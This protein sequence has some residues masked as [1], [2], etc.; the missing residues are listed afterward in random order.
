MTSSFL[1]SPFIFM[2]SLHVTFT[3]LSVALL[4]LLLLLLLLVQKPSPSVGNTP[5]YENAQKKQEHLDKIHIPLVFL[6]IDV[7]YNENPHSMI[8]R[9]IIHLNL[10]L[11]IYIARPKKPTNILMLCLGNLAL[12]SPIII[13]H[14][15]DQKKSTSPLPSVLS[16]PLMG[17]KNQ[18]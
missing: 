9:S 11:P 15:M 16:N 13:N 18:W 4:L 3:S 12:Y 10:V 17:N 1:P 14:P 6:K 7:L 2:S 8:T 5:P